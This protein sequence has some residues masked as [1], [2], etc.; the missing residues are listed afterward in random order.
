MRH[1]LA[2]AA[3]VAALLGVGTGTASA[4]RSGQWEVIAAPIV[5]PHGYL[6]KRWFYPVRNYGQAVVLAAHLTAEGWQV[7]IEPA[8]V[9]S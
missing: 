3:A 8:P 4:N 5:C 9:P 2:I 1:G 6:C 7:T